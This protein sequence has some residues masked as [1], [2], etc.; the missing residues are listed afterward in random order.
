VSLAN[1]AQPW[2]RVQTTQNSPNGADLPDALNPK[3]SFHQSRF[4]VSCRWPGTR[5]QNAMRDREATIADGSCSR[6]RGRQL[7]PLLSATPLGFGCVWSS[8]PR[9]ARR[10]LHSRR[11]TLGWFGVIPSGPLGN[12]SSRGF[13][14]DPGTPAPRAPDRPGWASRSAT[15]G[16]N[17]SDLRYLFASA[18]TKETR[19]PRVWSAFSGK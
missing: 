2:G 19:K 13:A 16:P 17:P 4:D 10:S 7:E 9:V 14:L 12:V 6:R 8:P 3:R 5:P 1:V 11:S 18:R 15:H